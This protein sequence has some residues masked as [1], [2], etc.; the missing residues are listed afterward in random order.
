MDIGTGE[1][2]K[3]PDN[4]R[5]EWWKGTTREWLFMTA[6]LRMSRDTLMVHYL[7]SH[8]AVATGTL[9]LKWS[10]RRSSLDFVCASSTAQ[11]ERA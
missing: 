1:V 3:L 7:S 9:L 8:I 6:D 2:V 4:I 10:H 5:D 11:L